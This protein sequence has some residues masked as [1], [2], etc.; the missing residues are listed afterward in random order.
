MEQRANINASNKRKAI[1]LVEAY[2]DGKEI[3][4]KDPQ[5]G[6]KDWMSI[7]SYNLWTYLDRFCENVDKYKIV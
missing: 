2:F 5:A 1:E 7:Y 3:L 6:I 4:V